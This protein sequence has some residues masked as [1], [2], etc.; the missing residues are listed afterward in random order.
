MIQVAKTL[1]DR[2]KSCAA[3]QLK[4]W[5]IHRRLSL[6]LTLSLLS[7]SLKSSLTAA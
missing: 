1:M 3:T 6:F 2:T 7:P 5:L 4:D